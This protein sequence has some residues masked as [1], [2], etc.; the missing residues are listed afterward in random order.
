MSNVEL[1]WREDGLRVSQ[2]CRRIKKAVELKRK[3][4]IFNKCVQ[5][6]IDIICLSSRP[7][8]SAFFRPYKVAKRMVLVGSKG[9][10]KY[11]LH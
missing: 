1:Q 7:V 10:A 9:H 2:L 3:G 11:L 4:M 6:D 8:S 5:F